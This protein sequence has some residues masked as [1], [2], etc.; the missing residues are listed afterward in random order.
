MKK[1]GILAAGEGLRLKTIALYKPMVKVCDV[2]LLELTLKNLHFKYFDKIC[3]IFNDEESKMDLVQFPTLKKLHI[4]Y[5]YMSTPSSMHSLFE[6]SKRL[7]VEPNEH[8][9]ISMVDSIIRPIDA[10]RFH[11]FCMTLK[12]DES[13]IIV[14]S[15]IEDEKPLTLKINAEGYVTEFQNPVTDNVLITSGVYYFSGLVLPLLAKE[16]SEGKTK[17]RNFLTELVKNGHKIKAFHIDKT[18]DI[19]RPEDIKS[20]ENFLRKEIQ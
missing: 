13:A 20:A 17:M 5:F 15:F 8:F 6:V 11:H 2:P 16:I 7:K 1:A 14:T 18:L 12:T 19:D 9:F 4:D 3:L 10:E